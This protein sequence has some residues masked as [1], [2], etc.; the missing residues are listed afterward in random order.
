MEA[1][2]APSLWRRAPLWR[3]C[4]YIGA[5]LS[6]LAVALPYLNP[7]K[8]ADK[9][10]VSMAP[11][12]GKSDGP[13]ST[14]PAP[15]VSPNAETHAPAP[16]TSSTASSSDVPAA[17]PK[18]KEHAAV[19]A[20]LAEP[21]TQNP[22]VRTKPASKSTHSPTIETAENKA[23]SSAPAPQAGASAAD[24]D[25]FSVPQGNAPM[26]APVIVHEGSAQPFVPVIG[27]A[28]PAQPSVI[29]A[30]HPTVIAGNPLLLA[31]PDNARMPVPVHPMSMN[32]TSNLWTDLDASSQQREKSGCLNSPDRVP[33]NSKIDPG[34]TQVFLPDEGVR[35][36]FKSNNDLFSI[37][38][39]TPFSGMVAGIRIGDTLAKVE[40]TQGTPFRDFPFGQQ[41][42]Y[43][44][45]KNM[46]TI[47][48]FDVDG[49]GVVRTMFVVSKHIR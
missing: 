10:Q 38:M 7:P 24:V 31:L 37:R 42:A 27:H 11:A 13:T 40:A 45:D 21:A 48:R 8:A 17:T 35:C 43:V 20:Q 12:A 1:Q 9:A 29:G 3:Y 47:D 39:D 41:H 19:A 34:E 26:T 16:A 32:E 4:C 46:G 15:T 6:I 30:K 44:F 18:K 36:F 25:E 22:V 14:S 33:S 5:G 23:P 28:R 2:L 49:D